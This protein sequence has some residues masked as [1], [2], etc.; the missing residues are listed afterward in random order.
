MVLVKVSCQSTSDLYVFPV[1]DSLLS[2]M[3]GGDRFRCL[4]SIV[5]IHVRTEILFN[6]LMC[7]YICFHCMLL[8]VLCFLIIIMSCEEG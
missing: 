2:H 5:T 1:E 3:S 4:R 6:S 8:S 7:R